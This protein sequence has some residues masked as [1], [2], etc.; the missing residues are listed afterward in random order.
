MEKTSFSVVE[1]EV[2]RRD[3]G[4]GLVLMGSIALILT[5]AMFIMAVWENAYY[6]LFSGR[7]HLLFYVAMGAAFIIAGAVLMRGPRKE[8]GSSPKQ[9]GN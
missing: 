2:T 8:Q 6:G 1:K 5:L 3:V 7:V 9:P 4:I